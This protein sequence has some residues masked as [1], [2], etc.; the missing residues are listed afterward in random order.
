MNPDDI[1]RAAIKAV[2]GCGHHCHWLPAVNY[3]NDPMDQQLVDAVLDNAAE[4][5][6]NMIRKPELLELRMAGKDKHNNKS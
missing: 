2:L 4:A 3:R 5:I 1:L 6:G